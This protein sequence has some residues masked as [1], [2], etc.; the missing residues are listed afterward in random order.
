MISLRLIAVFAKLIPSVRRS[1]DGRGPSAGP[2][3]RE[4]GE[5]ASQKS[6]VRGQ[7]RSRE[8]GIGEEKE[9]AN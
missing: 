7:K 2:R 6:R 5:R 1:V 8:K 4:G 3:K 9:G